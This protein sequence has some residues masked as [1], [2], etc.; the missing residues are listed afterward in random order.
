MPIFK[1]DDMKNLHNLHKEVYFWA[2]RNEFRNTIIEYEKVALYI[3]EIDNDLGQPICD[4][5]N[6]MYDAYYFK[7]NKLNE[8]IKVI[9]SNRIKIYSIFL[10]DFYSPLKRLRA[11]SA[12]AI[13]L[14]K[15]SISQGMAKAIALVDDM[16]LVY[17]D[18]AIE[19]YTKLSY[20]VD[21]QYGKADVLIGLI[22]EYV[23]R[24]FKEK[25]LEFEKDF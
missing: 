19:F 7:E 2:S 6:K 12:V 18:I 13:Q 8:M 17:K 5:V 23:G 25:I 4:Y 14:C 20:Y 22:E 11:D 9:N 1:Y 21:Y 3:W 10:C 15:T 16:K 24:I